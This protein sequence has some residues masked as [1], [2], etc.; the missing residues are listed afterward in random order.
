MVFNF[1]SQFSCSHS[2]LKAQVH[3]P[4]FICHP[5]MIFFSDQKRALSFHRQALPL[6]HSSS[7]YFKHCLSSFLEL[8]R[9]RARAQGPG[10]K[11]SSE[12]KLLSWAQSLSLS[13]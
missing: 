9:A 3:N 1:I 6:F 12:V 2:L 4:L 7:I 8:E 5:K 10:H 11:S 13:Q